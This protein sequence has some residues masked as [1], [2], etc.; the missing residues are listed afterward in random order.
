MNRGVSA[1]GEIMTMIA[2]IQL[3]SW[4]L[5]HGSLA[6][7]ELYTADVHLHSAVADIEHHMHSFRVLRLLNTIRWKLNNARANE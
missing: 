5:E 1:D 4:N 6:S 2:G 7:A 3:T